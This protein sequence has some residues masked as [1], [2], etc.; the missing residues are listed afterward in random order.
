[1][2]KKIQTLKEKR[3]PLDP[4]DRFAEIMFGLIMTLSFIG[5]INVAEHGQAEIHTLL[6]AALGCNIAWGIVD[7]VMFWLTRMIGRARRRTIGNQI[8]KTSD[9]LTAQKILSEVLPEELEPLLETDALIPLVEKIKNHH[10]LNRPPLM[11][12]E[13]LG[14]A[15]LVCILVILSTVPA[16]LPFLFLSNVTLAVKISN[17]ITL[18]ILFS[19]GMSLGQ[20]SGQKKFQLGLMM[21]IIGV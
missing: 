2:L 3:G 20:F 17:S 14:G 5:T 7:G 6:F 15:F 13:D 8:R 18:A 9:S 16:S 21:V 1:M 11:T 4:V 10:P 12:L 19:L